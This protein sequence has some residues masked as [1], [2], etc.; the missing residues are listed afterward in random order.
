[1]MPGLAPV[2][3]AELVIEGNESCIEMLHRKRY[4]NRALSYNI[5]TPLLKHCN[6]TACCRTTAAMP[7]QRVASYE[8]HH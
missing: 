2:D 7:F 4:G 6:T 1:M 8:F 3:M 5:E